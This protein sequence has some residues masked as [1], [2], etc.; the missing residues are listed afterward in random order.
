MDTQS[1]NPQTAGSPVRT[2]FLQRRSPRLT[3]ML[4]LALAA[5]LSLIALTPGRAAFAQPSTRASHK[6]PA[7]VSNS[8]SGSS[9]YNLTIASGGQSWRRIAANQALCPLVP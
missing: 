3:R 6:P 2:P 8:G 1:T 9:C 4:A 5:T 7:S